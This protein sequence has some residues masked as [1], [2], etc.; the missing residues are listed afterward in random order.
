MWKSG[1]GALKRV[2]VAVCRMKSIDFCNDTIEITGIHFSYNKKKWNEKYF[3][4]SITKTQNVLEVWKM[5]CLGLEGKI[6]VYKT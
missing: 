2:R 1:T 6:I 3:L 5:H 4:E